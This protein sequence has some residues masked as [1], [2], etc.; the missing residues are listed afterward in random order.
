MNRRQ[1]MVGMGA[2]IAGAAAASL[3]MAARGAG[4]TA[5]RGAERSASAMRTRRLG[6]TGHRSSLITFGG[7]VVAGMSQREADRIVAEALDAGINEFDVAPSYGDAEIKLGPALRGKRALVFLQCKTLERS[8]KG[9]AKELRESLKRLGTDHIDLYQFH[10][11][12]NAA[13]LDTILGPGGAMEAVTQ[14]RDAGHTRFIGITGHR[15][16]TLVDALRRFPFDTVMAPVNFVLEHRSH[17][18]E[19]L[20][21]EA[22]RRGVGVIAI[23]ALAE[24]PWLAGDERKYPKC[25]YK[26]VEDDHLADLALRFTLSERVATAIPPGDERLLRK[27]I[28]IARRYRA[29]RPA[30]RVEL[31]TIADGLTP[32]F[33]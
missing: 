20:L 32:I 8:F 24:R 11:I 23:K 9:A 4:A 21:A 17:Y 3:A 33:E 25:W 5:T 12:N 18:A 14:A 30:E 22:R 16:R 27:A 19:T 13:E 1:F 6:G 7:I 29:L 10:G 26:P 15:P 2:T 28:A 31:A